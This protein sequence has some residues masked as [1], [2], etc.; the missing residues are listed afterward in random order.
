MLYVYQLIDS[1]L[2]ESEN[3]ITIVEQDYE[4][5]EE[6][7]NN[8][9]VINIKADMK[10]EGSFDMANKK[11]S[12]S[13]KNATL[14]KSQLLIE[15]NEYSLVIGLKGKTSF[16]ELGRNTLTFN[17]EDL[18]FLI[19]DDLPLLSNDMF[20]E[21]DSYKLVAYAIE[22]SNEKEYKIT[23]DFSVKI[24]N[25]DTISEETYREFNE[26]AVVYQNIDGVNKKITYSVDAKETMTYTYEC[27]DD[28]LLV[29]KDI[30]QERESKIKKT[31]NA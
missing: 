12:L 16:I 19:D 9:R 7:E 17:N 31:E 10:M 15:G 11:I 6:K 30:N 27:D 22:T 23:D 8:D 13:E 24:G 14:S 25:F 28:N 26:E 3:T 29:I 18:S 20:S 1:L 4:E 21:A 2:D 5:G